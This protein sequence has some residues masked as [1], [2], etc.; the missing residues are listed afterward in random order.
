MAWDEEVEA[1]E[2]VARPID[3][4]AEETDN[5]PFAEEVEEPPSVTPE[6]VVTRVMETVAD[7][8]LET[9][10]DVVDEAATGAHR[11]QGDTWLLNLTAIAEGLQGVNLTD[12]V[13]LQG[14]VLNITALVE[15]VPLSEYFPVLSLKEWTQWLGTLVMIAFSTQWIVLRIQKWMRVQRGWYYTLQQSKHA[16]LILPPECVTEAPMRS[17]F[18]RLTKKVAR[19]LSRKKRNGEY[20]G[21]SSIDPALLPDDAVPLL[22]FVNSRSGGQLGGYLIHMF[23]QNLNPLQVVDLHKTDPKVALRQFCE[24]PRVRILVCGGDGTVAW[25][26]QTMESLSGDTPKPPVGILP[27]GT[28]NDL[29]RVLGWGGG[30]NNDLISELLLQCLE[31][32]PAILDRWEV[33]ITPRD[34]NGP[35][36]SPRKGK[37]RL[38][39]SEYNKVTEFED[40]HDA[41]RAAGVGRRSSRLGRGNLGGAVAGGSGGSAG[42]AANAARVASGAN[43]GH[44]DGDGLV[45]RDDVSPVTTTVADTTTHTNPKELVFQNYL[46]IGVDAQAALRFH[47]TRTVSPHLFFSAFTNKILYGL[48]GFRDVVEHSC[49]GLHKHV[50]VICDGVRCELP[51]ETEGLILLNINSFAGGVRMWEQSEGYGA[52]SMQDGMVDVVVVYGALHLGQLNWGVDKPVRICQARNVKVIMDKGFPMHVDGEPW[53]QP[54][55]TIDI[56]LRNKA[57]ML[58]RTADARGM[59]IVKMNDTLEWAFGNEIISSTQRDEIMAEAYRRAEK[60]RV[61][62]MASQRSS[63]LGN[64]VGRHRR[65]RSGGSDGSGDFY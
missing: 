1:E 62:S 14:W 59:S 46:G 28:G 65:G 12:G 61:I 20:T 18:T 7:A 15:D 4:V 52:S 38:P 34:V 42:T 56:K 49:A 58:R 57:L 54:A 63:S 26:L 5:E 47:R 23:R 53:E 39:D 19:K 25:I 41:T 16:R 21:I 2:V 11:I 60:E 29:A 10:Q 43:A 31:A 55:C 30:F 22:V 40:A 44:S 27:L 45:T 24:L 3:F 17:P 37:R 48:F 36:P 35:P 32:H 50:H 9:V 33:S 13:N 51:P 64:L 8:V 6:S